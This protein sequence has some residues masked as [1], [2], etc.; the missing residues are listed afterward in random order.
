MNYDLMTDE[1]LVEAIR[2]QSHRVE[3]LRVHVLAG[4]LEREVLEFAMNGLRDLIAEDLRR[5][6]PGA[7]GDA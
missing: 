2:A 7:S 6:A 4:T 3:A 1:L 5:K